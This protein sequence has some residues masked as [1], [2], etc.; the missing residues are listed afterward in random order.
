MPR[1]NKLII[2]LN[3]NGEIMPI[4]FNELDRVLNKLGKRV[5]S[6]ARKVLKQQKKVVTGNLSKS[7][8][9]NIE[10]S[11][12]SVELNFE[13]NAPY[14]DFVEQGVKG[15]ISSAKAPD[16]PYQFGSGKEQLM[17]GTLR[18]GI[19]KWVI[20]KPIAGIRG[21][22]G[23]FVPRKQM[24][25]AISTEI[26]NYGIAPSNYYSI[27]LDQGYNKS[28]RLIAKAIGVDV[29]TFVEENL[30]GTY[31]LTITI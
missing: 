9:Y 20:Q 4:Q 8:Y 30:T 18:G 2:K 5:V 17:K 3:V 7:L 19:D 27:A 16:S 28:K 29:S 14:W 10:G 23:R 31:N 12:E 26:Y 24:V 13:A 11:K 1:I 25:S 6:N 15:L 21:A 22:N